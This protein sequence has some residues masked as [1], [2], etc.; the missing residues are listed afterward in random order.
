MQIDLTTEQRE[1]ARRA[2]ETGRVRR[3]EDA[4]KQAP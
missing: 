2:L 1:F 4:V 3:E